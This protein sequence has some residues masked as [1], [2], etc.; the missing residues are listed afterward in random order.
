MQSAVNKRI[1]SIDILRGIVMVLMALDH[2]RDFFSNF[3]HAPTDLE[4]TNTAMFFTRWITH[5]CAP[6]FIFLSGSSAF[7]SMRKGKTKGQAALFLLSR[8]IWLIILEMT[9]V[10]FGWLFNLNYQLVVA[11]V[12][13]AIGWS[14]VCLSLLIFLPLPLL[15]IISLFIIGTH[16]FFLDGIAASQF[17]DNKLWWYLLHEQ[18][19]ATVGNT[20]FFVAYPLIPWIAVMSLGYCFGK[21]LLLEERRRN[22]YLYGIGLIAILLFIILRYNNLYGNPGNWYAQ[23][24]LTKSIMAFLNCEKYPPSL[25]YLLMT[26]G[27]AIALMPVLEKARGM[28]ADFFMVFG[29]VPMFY[30]LLHLY[31]I[32]G[33]AVLLGFLRG[34]SINSFTRGSFNLPEGWGYGLPGVYLAWALAIGLLY[35]PCRWFMRVKMR[36]KDWWL[37]YL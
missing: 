35:F 19:G 7:L 27:P 32:H 11:Q 20:M 22:T 4:H 9:F 34:F 14:M 26:L 33:M 37:S 6:V 8:G 5:F 23:G 30:Y 13:W 15:A 17:S 36:R 16:N 29:K 2:T 31:I 25:L 18:N 24:S 1:T 28:V 3:Q 21:I 10:R 12:I